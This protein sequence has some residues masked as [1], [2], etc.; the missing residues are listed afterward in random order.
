M[1]DLSGLASVVGTAF[2][3]WLKLFAAPLKNLDMLWIIVP[4]WGNWFFA[5]FFQ[6]KKGTSFGNAISNGAVM[7]F[8]GIDWLRY[9]IGHASADGSFFIGEVLLELFVA[10]FILILGLTIIVMGIKAKRLVRV[11]GRIR[12]ITYLMLMFTPIVYGVVE[13]NIRNIILIVAFLPVFYIVIELIDRIVP[14]PKTYE[15]EEG[16]AAMKQ[17]PGTPDLGISPNLGSDFGPD[18]FGSAQ[19]GF[20]QQPQQQA[21]WPPQ[22]PQQWQGWPQQQA[23]NQGRQN[24]RF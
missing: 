8:V 16:E 4:I 13:F 1:V 18:V 15:V 5:E 10:A 23:P 3:D 21:Q 24:R 20:P 17:G 12:E 22:P 7:L 9:A 19:P 11:V 2:I 6:E 14:N